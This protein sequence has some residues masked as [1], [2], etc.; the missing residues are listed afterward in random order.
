MKIQGRQ[1]RETERHNLWEVVPLKAP[2]VV[3]IEPTNLC[4]LRCKY[5]PT[6]DKELTKMRPNGMMNWEVYKKAIDDISQFGKKIKRLNLYKDGEPLLN[7]EFPNMVKYAKDMG[8][9]EE[10][11]V[12]TNGVLLD[13]KYNERLVNCG[14]DM[15]GISVCHVNKKGYLNVCGVHIDYEIFRVD[16]ADLF[17]RHFCYVYVKIADFGLSKEE[18]E[19]F[20]DDFESICDYIAIEGLHG[21]SMSSVK[22]F[23]LGTKNTFDGTPLTEKI[24]CPWT[25]YAMTINW[26]GTVSLCNEDWAHKTIIGD[27]KE[28]SLKEIWNGEEVYQFR[29]MHLENRRHENEACKDCYYLKVLPDNIDEHREEIL[30]KL[31]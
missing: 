29:K 12:K 26:N 31:S 9:A 16:I 28:K 25:L 19:K 23:T 21:W 3:Y 10:I 24:A 4:N 27:I 17:N 8:V 6:G 20:Y 1:L 2:W 22:D 15:I 13:P 11:W 30:D 7:R 14:L 5:C 18:K